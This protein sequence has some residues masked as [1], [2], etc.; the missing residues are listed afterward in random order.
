MFLIKSYD[1][2]GNI[3]VAASIFNLKLRMKKPHFNSSKYFGVMCFSLSS[4]VLH[5]RQTNLAA[6]EE[7]AVFGG[8][9]NSFRILLFKISTRRLKF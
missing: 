3:E 4:R 7:V 5:V 1:R 6:D 9:S 2:F 8:G